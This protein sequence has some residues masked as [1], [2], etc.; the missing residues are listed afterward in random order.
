M[1]SLPLLLIQLFSIF[2]ICAQDTRKLHDCCFCE[3]P[4]VFPGGLT[5]FYKY[6]N[7]SVAKKIVLRSDKIPEKCF[8]Q[9]TIDAEGRPV[10]ANI[11]KTSAFPEIDS[12]FLSA[13]RKMP[14]WT[15]ACMNNKLV[16]Q[17]YQVPLHICIRH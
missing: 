6:I 14:L 8:A 1:R 17:K 13:L 16:S 15:P 5:A 2:N 12:I 10:N 4:A 9:F 3:Q 11:I 7:D